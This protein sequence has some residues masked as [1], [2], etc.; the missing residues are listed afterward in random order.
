[1]LSITDA[2]EGFNESQLRHNLDPRVRYDHKNHVPL[3]GSQVESRLIGNTQEARSIKW[4][5]EAVA[6]MKDL[7]VRYGIG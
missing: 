5:N 6:K 4:M 1:M 3:P 7:I 2:G